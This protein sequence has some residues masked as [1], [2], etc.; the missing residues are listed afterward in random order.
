[1][2]DI[3]YATSFLGAGTYST[4]V[5]VVATDLS[6]HR[7]WT[8][9]VAVSLASSSPDQSANTNIKHFYD[10]LPELASGRL[11]ASL[12]QPG[13]IPYYRAQIVEGTSFVKGTTE[14]GSF[15]EAVMAILTSNLNKNHEHFWRT[16]DGTETNVMLVCMGLGDK[17]DLSETDILEEA[18]ADRTAV[19]QWLFT[20]MW[21]L[22]VAQRT[23]NFEHRDIKLANVVLSDDGPGRSTFKLALSKSQLE[24]Q[25]L[26]DEHAQVYFAI[27]RREGLTTLVPKFVDLNFASYVVSSFDYDA[28]T[29]ENVSSAVLA[30]DVVSGQLLPPLHFEVNY[31][32]R[33]VS[34]YPSPDM[35]FYP[36][37]DKRDFDSDVFSLGIA[38]LEL[39]VGNATWLVNLFKSVDV[40]SFQDICLSEAAAVLHPPDINHVRRVIRD[41]GRTLLS[42][43][44][45]F[46][47]LHGIWQ[48]RIVTDELRQTTLFRI[49]ERPSIKAFLVAVASRSSLANDIVVLQRVH[50][51]DALDFLRSCL[52]WDKAERGV[53]PGGP[54]ARWQTPA[55]FRLLL[56]PY[57]MPLRSTNTDVA[58]ITQHYT[59]NYADPPQVTELLLDPE[60]KTR[61]ARRILAVETSVLKQVQY[62]MTSGCFE[63]EMDTLVHSVL[64]EE[65]EKTRRDDDEPLVV[66]KKPRPESHVGDSFTSLEEVSPQPGV[67]QNKRRL[68][69]DDE[70]LF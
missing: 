51:Q 41:N 58:A 14:H 27:N 69:A 60:R 44:Q 25:G 67:M 3:S 66:S 18:R 28:D 47:A 56:H 40:K 38:A 63:L 33:G 59:L 64:R 8:F 68:W 46:S 19:R 15:L 49:L 43:V 20:L 39:M 4:V 11:T 5:R 53:F 29:L 48:P 6:S 31:A 42:Y 9:A 52:T 17:G 13:F 1:M 22:L 26:R 50:G 7:T 23:F 36:N 55:S 32:S 37:G 21:S 54:A 65:R 70:I 34:T 35:F 12:R 45:L 61:I 10:I 16:F 62:P 2:A 30:P 57:F 24:K